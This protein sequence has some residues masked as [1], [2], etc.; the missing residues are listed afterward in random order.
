MSYS[1]WIP[2]VKPRPAKSFPWRLIRKIC[3]IVKKITEIIGLKFDLTGARVVG[4]TPSGNT[5]LELNK[6]YPLG[7]KGTVLE[8]P[9]D[10]VI[11]EYVRRRGLWELEE[12][13]FLAHGLLRIG[14]MPKSKTA[15]L[16]IGANVGLITLQALN[17]SKTSPEIFLFEPINR[18]VLAIQHNLRKFSNIHIN[19][20]ALSNEN[21]I[22]EI[23]TQETNHGNT[24]LLNS[25][26]PPV[27]QIRTQIRVV[28]TAQYCDSFL[29]TFDSFIIKCDTQGMDA[30]ILSRIGNRIWE[31]TEIA[32]IECWA[33]PEISEQNVT[34]LLLMFQKFEYASWDPKSCKTISLNE[35]SEFWL[36]KS[37]ASRVLFLSKS[38]TTAPD[39]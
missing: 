31:N 4:V 19:E 39:K 15:L 28:D 29:S 2:F 34:D 13:E 38:G 33:L 37:G 24:T 14:G 11:F 21:G 27:E 35:I 32:V 22:A 8:L 18:H 1:S 36:S 7:L 12:S 5:L 23:Y 16:D 10:E 6:N 26:V 25:I 20:F 3:F 17:L 9:K 30:L